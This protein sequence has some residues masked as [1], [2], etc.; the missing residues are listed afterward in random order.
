MM[1]ILSQ[2]PN[3]QTSNSQTS[4]RPHYSSTPYRN[5]SHNNNTVKLVDFNTL[6]ANSM[7]SNSPSDVAV[8]S[9]C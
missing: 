5:K 7:V 9:E 1:Q 4:I 6:M 2:F 8:S 3:R